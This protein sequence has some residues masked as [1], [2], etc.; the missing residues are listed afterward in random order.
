MPTFKTQNYKALVISNNLLE[1]ALQKSKM[2]FDSIRP[3]F[4]LMLRPRAL[5]CCERHFD[6]PREL[7]ARHQFDNV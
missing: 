5:I 4:K 7:S 1:Q 2:S 3:A 6:W